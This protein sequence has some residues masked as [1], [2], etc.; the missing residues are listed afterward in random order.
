MSISIDFVHLSVYVF[1]SAFIMLFLAIF[2]DVFSTAAASILP[3]DLP[4]IWRHGVTES[5]DVC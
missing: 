3:L 5:R 1:F 4:Y 2:F